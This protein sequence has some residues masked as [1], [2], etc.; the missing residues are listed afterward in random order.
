MLSPARSLKICL[1]ASGGGHVRQLLDL[2]KA[3]AAYDHFF[4]TEDTALGRSIAADHRTHL[5]AH[6]A[7]GQARLGAPFRMAAAGLRNFVQSMGIIFRERPDV[8]ISTGAGSVY[9]AVLWA[10][11]L[12]ARVVVVESFARFDRLS[13]FAKIAGPLAHHKVV[14]SQ[15]LKAFWPDAEVFDPLKLLDRPRPA[16]KPL[17]FATV[18][19]TLSFDRLVRAVAELKARG[20]IPEEVI[21]QT[22]EGGLAPEGVTVVETLPFD[23]VLAILRDADIVVCHGGTGSLITA[24]REG[25]RLVAVPRLFELG[26]HY[27]NHQAEITA[28]FQ[29]RGLLEVARTSED[30]SR[31]LAAVR[32]REPA[33]ATSDPAALTQYLQE[34]LAGLAAR[35]SPGAAAQRQPAGET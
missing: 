23:E 8:V 10:R 27:D 9:F 2:S 30:L 13:A 20:E 31:A 14:Q 15:A 4:I 25:C 29:D 18:G 3:W 5:V 12:G 35:R 7:L 6:V 1:A 32:A 26:E 17:L 28:A 21:V 34:I 24:L 16:K 22:G 11:L 19:A 33:V